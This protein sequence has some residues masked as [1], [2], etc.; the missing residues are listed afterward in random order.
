MQGY[1]KFAQAAAR[2][3]RTGEREKGKETNSGVASVSSTRQGH[4]DGPCKEEIRAKDED[5]QPV[6]RDA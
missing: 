5:R 6:D 1:A 4:D 2:Q 3:E